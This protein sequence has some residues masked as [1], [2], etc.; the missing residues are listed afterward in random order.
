MQFIPLANL[1][2]ADYGRIQAEQSRPAEYVAAQVTPDPRGWRGKAILAEPGV[3]DIDAMKQLDGS[4][5][6]RRLRAAGKIQ[7]V[8]CRDGQRRTGSGRENA[9]NLPPADDLPCEIIREKRFSVAERKLVD[10]ALHIVQGAIKIGSGVIP[11]SIDIENQAAIVAALEVHGLAPS[12]RGG[13]AKPA[14]KRPIQLHL[15]RVVA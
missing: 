2:P 8:V 4:D 10:I 12:E 13:H 3:T 1:N 11:L 15:Q 9:R 14:A 5:L 6:I 7:G